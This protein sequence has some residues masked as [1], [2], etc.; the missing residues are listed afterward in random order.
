MINTIKHT[1]KGSNKL[2]VAKG[3][4]SSGG[5]TERGTEEEDGVVALKVSQDPK[6][7]K[8]ADQLAEEPGQLGD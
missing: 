5:Q 8:L 3:S 2:G 6:I 1:P 7:S 4:G